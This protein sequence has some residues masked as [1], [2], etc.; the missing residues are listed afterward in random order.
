MFDPDNAFWSEMRER[1]DFQRGWNSALWEAAKLVDDDELDRA[2]ILEALR[3]FAIS[4]P[5]RRGAK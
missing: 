4:G 2:T 1:P 5:T 3:R